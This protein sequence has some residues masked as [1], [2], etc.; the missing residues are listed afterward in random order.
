MQHHARHGT[1]PLHASTSMRA[2]A[3]GAAR[4]QCRRAIAGE[5]YRTLSPIRG[6]PEVN[7]PRASPRYL[8]VA[9]LGLFPHESALALAQ[10]SLLCFDVPMIF[11]A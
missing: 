7:G 1:A 2:S 11:C 3:A 5:H 4:L 6:H 10:R 8:A 9:G